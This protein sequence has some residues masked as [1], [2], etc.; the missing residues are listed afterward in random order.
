MGAGSTEPARRTQIWCGQ[1]EFHPLATRRLRRLRN[2]LS[3]RR[4]C[5]LRLICTL[6][7]DVA[8]EDFLQCTT[9]I[10]KYLPSHYAASDAG[11]EL[12]GRRQGRNHSGK[13]FPSRTT[14]IK[15]SVNSAY[16]SGTATFGI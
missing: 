3:Y 14:R 12:V 8:N 5:A 4:N 11:E 9:I 7:R 13:L 6:V 15:W 16:V 10:R 2:I 1:R